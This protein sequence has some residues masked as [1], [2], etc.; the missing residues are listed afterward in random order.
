[1]IM[2]DGSLFGVTNGPGSQNV[3][4]CAECHA[5]VA[6]DQDSLFFLPEEFRLTSR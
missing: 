1:M 4:F 3:Q 6:D 2:P 5:I